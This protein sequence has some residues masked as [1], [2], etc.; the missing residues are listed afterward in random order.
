MAYGAARAVGQDITTGTDRWL[1]G[2][3]NPMARARND[4]NWIS[5][6]V[7]GS[8]GIF[9][10]NPV[11]AGLAY[12]ATNTVMQ[13][14]LEA[15]AA[16][17]TARQSANISLNNFFGSR[18]GPSWQSEVANY[19]GRPTFGRG[20]IAPGS[21]SYE[22]PSRLQ[23]LTDRTD[24]FLPE[25]MK[26]R[27]PGN[28]ARVMGNIG[29]NLYNFGIDPF[30]PGEMVHDPGSQVPISGGDSG[31]PGRESWTA[32]TD[33]PGTASIRFQSEVV[34]APGSAGGGGLVKEPD[35]NYRMPGSVVQSPGNLKI[36]DY[37]GA[38]HSPLVQAPAM[39]PGSAP[40]GTSV[41]FGGLVQAP[42]G[43]NAPGGMV[44]APGEQGTHP[45]MGLRDIP[46]GDFQE[47][48]ME[49]YFRRTGILF[50]KDNAAEAWKRIA[51]AFD[52]YLGGNPETD[53]Q[54]NIA[55]VLTKIG[56]ADTLAYLRIRDP[57]LQSSVDPELLRRTAGSL[58]VN[59]RRATLGGLKATGSGA[60]E[61]GAFEAD[62]DTLSALPE[63]RDSIAYAEADYK[64]RGARSKMWHQGDIMDFGLE[65]VHLRGARQRAELNPYAPGDL[66]AIDVK[67]IGNNKRQIGRLENRL[68]L[69]DLSEDERYDI[70]SQ[71]ESLRTQNAASIYDLVQN[72]PN[73]LPAMSAGAPS[74]FARIDSKQ[75]TAMAFGAIGHP[76]RG[77]GAVN[78]NQ[79][80]MQRRF[81]D[82]LLSDADVSPGEIAPR[83]R[84]QNL[85]H[86]MHGGGGGG[87]LGSG[88]GGGNAEIAGLLR[89]LIAAVRQGN[90]GA[91]GGRMPGKP[92]EVVGR[93]A[94]DLYGKQ[95][96]QS[97]SFKD[98]RGGR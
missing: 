84:S 87:S 79:L 98:F 28:A 49:T 80:A 16:P 93:V 66:F 21:V 38:I 77:A 26:F 5:T 40:F 58:R 63:G 94:G 35:R 6:A 46:G 13:P 19:T 36:P 70:S 22:D 10:G 31:K 45:Q 82:G 75:M 2:G 64:R 34:Q 50:G 1:A 96:S 42:G 48:R 65:D 91:G 41:P 62:M 72:V 73:R 88:A 68:K 92:S 15:G 7:G 44:Q 39:V 55:D 54:A 97:Y 69:G 43:G 74:F 3:D 20:M 11:L 33:M 25:E 60:A 76:Y 95:D 27:N 23:R 59:A 18:F 56:P 14:I 53:S 89:E 24:R 9:T 57:N 61:M 85:D 37:S 4:A 78:S 8:V 51:P 12:G 71:D 90:S 30:A 17:E 67:S 32:E 29:A 52:P 86:A 47:N 83:G 81:V